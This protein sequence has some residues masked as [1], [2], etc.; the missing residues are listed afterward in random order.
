MITV[1]PHET[2]DSLLAAVAQDRPQADQGPIPRIAVIPSLQFSDHLQRRIADVTGIC[3][4]Y[5]F[6]MPQTFIHRII[7]GTRGHSESAWSKRSLTWR[8]LPHVSTFE[9]A[10]GL[11]TD[12][13]RDRFAL[14]M[15]L[16][17]RIDQ[18]GHFRPD[19]VRKWATGADWLP[20]SASG[21]DKAKEKW[22]KRLWAI[23]ARETD[24]LH[25]ALALHN[26]SQDG[27]LLQ[28]LRRQFPNLM[29]IGTGSIDPLLV[30]V[31]GLL[32]TAGSEI[33][34]HVILPTLAFLGDLHRR[35]AMP[36]SNIFAEEFTPVVVHSLLASMGRHSIGSFLL[37]GQ[38]DEQYANWPA[39]IERIS[40]DGSSLLHS[41]QSDIRGLQ[42][43]RPVRTR[44]DDSSIRVHA[45]YGPRREMETVRDEV[46]RALVEIDGLRPED[47]HIATVSHDAYR[48][49][50][51]AVLQLWDQT[52]LPVRVTE[53][54][55]SEGNAITEG[56]LALLEVA[57]KGVFTAIDVI[58]LLNLRC[59]QAALNISDEDL[60]IER[61]R[62]WITDSGL[63]R[64]L[65]ERDTPG[66]WMHARNRLVAGS[67]FGT[68]HDA[69]YPDGAFVLPLADDLDGGAE[70]RDQFLEWFAK[71][72]EAMC[73]WS[74]P[75]TPSAWAE[76]LLSAAQSLLGGE[77]DAML[78]LRP[79]L[80]FLAGLSC[81]EN[82]D[83]ATAGDWLAQDTGQRGRRSAPWGGV[84][85]G[86]LKQLQNIPCRVLII[87]GMQDG[88][89]PSR[90]IE[91]PWDLL[92]CDPRSWDRNARVDDR[93]QFLDAVLT[94][95]DRLVIT[96]STRNP[97]TLKERPFSSC[98][99]ELL[100]VLARMGCPR[101]DVVVS[102]PLQP[103]SSEYF[104]GERKELSSFDQNSASIAT[105]VRKPDP[106]EGIPFWSDHPSGEQ[107]H[108]EPES[109]D[110][111]DLVRFWKDPAAAFIRAHDVRLPHSEDD[112][113]G[114]DRLPLELEA[115]DRWKLQNFILGEM[116]R[117]DSDLDRSKAEAL[118]QRLLPSGHL[119]DEHW[120][121]LCD[122]TRALG[123]MILEH[124]GN[125]SFVAVIAGQP[126][127]TVTSHV[128]LS[129]DGRHLLVWRPGD[130]KSAKHYIGP[131]INAVV[132]GAAG[133]ELPSLIFS[134]D[135]THSLHD[136]I[137]RDQALSMLSSLIAGFREGHS[138]PLCYLPS[139]SHQYGKLLPT[140]EDDPGLLRQAAEKD[141][142]SWNPQQGESAEYQLAWR[143]KNALEDWKSWR[144]WTY[145]FAIPLATWGNFR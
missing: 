80:E 20:R 4:G 3:M 44:G 139:L 88:E 31:L 67:W 48:P 57:R 43:P 113:Q 121:R 124:R 87:T 89:F 66:S 39:F 135:G 105:A 2:F 96:A 142:S 109:L 63:T 8:I 25:P 136:A 50:I 117:D 140:G 100:R 82:I 45:C 123:R 92:R 21:E 138:K 94:P 26:A 72:Q 28:D 27:D 125:H 29:V 130:F 126:P 62:R 49:Y 6:V 53:L 40:G 112:N 55:P 5:D 137:P 132:S 7:A 115:L 118:G 51:S 19:M 99:D 90:S 12:S 14:S 104:T 18:Y 79:N 98:V 91:P 38:L 73:L 122:E 131:W 46:L 119:G 65:G 34:V 144:D 74:H 129:K 77:S 10:L 114:L 32:S 127:L 143:D 83:A 9:R 56:L 17:D 108:E 75:A 141:A 42:T 84:L 69:R 95:T 101:T 15:Q 128:I 23:L 59:V 61:I 107:E 145:K 81:S 13:P 85:C 36:E 71:L 97:R 47:I 41:L 54:A 35:R 86:R 33:Q 102:H 37:L 93:Q 11:E 52:R 70:L 58:E 106:L 110:A 64:G 60:G 68:N 103:F 30:E 133:L 24:E 76:R 22:Q 116:L 1:F 120:A 16:A 134:T 111:V 78:G